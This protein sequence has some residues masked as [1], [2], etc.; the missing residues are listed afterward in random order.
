M[1]KAAAVTPYA[2]FAAVRAAGLPTGGGLPVVVDKTEA[3]SL[4]DTFA[5]LACNQKGAGQFEYMMHQ[6]KVTMDVILLAE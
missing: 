1:A 2:L 3:T 5:A 6:A 4:T